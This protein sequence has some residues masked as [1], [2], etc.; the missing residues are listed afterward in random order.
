M[1]KF[2]AAGLFVTNMEKMVI[3]YRDVMGMATEWDG[4]PNA[5][6]FSGGMRLIMFSR[7]DFEEMTSQ[8]YTYPSGK[9]G[10]I[11]LSFSLPRFEDVDKEY[12]RVVAEGAAAVFAPADMPWGQR[13][14][15]V[16]DPDGNLVEISSFN[17]G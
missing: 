2:D 6:L 12:Q 15:Y 1:L 14:S 4:A 7:S 13:T 11:E 9:N 3:F 17:A 10:T 16:A 5:E 8:Q